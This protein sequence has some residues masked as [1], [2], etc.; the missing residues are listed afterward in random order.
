MR[1]GELADTLSLVLEGTV[2]VE[3]P[4]AHA[5]GSAWAT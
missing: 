1:I 4:G 3:R 2:L 5:D